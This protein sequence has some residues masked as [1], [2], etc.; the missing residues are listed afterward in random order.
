MAKFLT[1]AEIYRM[2][3]RE[4]PEGVYPDGAPSGFYST[5]DMDSVADVAATGYVNLSRIYDNYFPQTTVESIEAWE[6]KI[7]GYVQGADQSL[8]T[9]QDNILT[10][11]RNPFGITVASM[12]AVVQ[13][14]IGTSH[15]IE[16]REWNNADGVWTIGESELGISTILGGGHQLDVTPLLFPGADLCAG[17]VNP[18][19]FGKTAD[20]WAIMQEQAYTYEV[21]IFGYTLTASER[22]RIDQQLTINE[23]ARSQHIIT[24][25]LD[26]ADQINGDT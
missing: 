15:P 2:L 4:L 6:I 25:G 21:L 1:R 10:K 16:I 23:P 14:V 8:E 11:I 26:L 13:S 22:T 20:Q 17:C 9:R 3:Q 7:F 19:V 24:D 18:A 5:A 12:I